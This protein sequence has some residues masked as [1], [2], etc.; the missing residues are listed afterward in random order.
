[1]R[2]RSE[3]VFY[4]RGTIDTAPRDGTFVIIEDD[5]A[6]TF[7][8]AQWSAEAR[9][10]LGE[11]GEPS[12]ITPTYWQTAHLPQEG[13][14]FIAPDEFRWSRAVATSMSSPSASPE[15]RSFRFPAGQAASQRAADAGRAVRQVANADPLTVARLETRATQ[16]KSERAPPAR[17]WFAVSSIAAVMVAT[18]LIGYISTPSSPPM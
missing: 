10:W 14:E 15:P 6:G 3:G 5:V 11:N 7:E 16:D 9:G 12:K 13:D 18:S 1:L 8:R 17:R 2:N 4:M